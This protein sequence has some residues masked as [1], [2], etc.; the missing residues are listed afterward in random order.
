MSTHALPQET[1]CGAKAARQVMPMLQGEEP[2]TGLSG[3]AAGP[4]RCN[5]NTACYV[6][7]CLNKLDTTGQSPA[8]AASPEQRY[9]AAS[10]LLGAGQAAAG[11]DG[12]MAASQDLAADLEPA[13]GTGDSSSNQRLMLSTML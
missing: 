7:A 1:N 5:Y 9:P 12:A 6:V 2:M 3:Q 8:A 11:G 13:A 4:G 10:Q